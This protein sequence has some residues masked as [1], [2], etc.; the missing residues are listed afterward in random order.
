MFR[1]NERREGM[2]VAII[3]LWRNWCIA[4]GLLAVLCMLAT[5]V[6][7][8]W[9]VLINLSFYAVLQLVH[10]DQVVRKV[11][12]CYRLLKQVSAV[13]LVT[14]VCCFVLYIMGKTGHRIPR[15]VEP[16]AIH[17]P[18]MA[19]LIT[20]PV[21]A[22]VSLIYQRL[23]HEPMLCRHCN[24]RCLTTAELGSVDDLL[25]QEGRYQASLLFSLS[26]ILSVVDW[27]Y[28]LTLYVDGAMRTID[29]LFFIIFPF[30]IYSVTSL[31]LGWR[32][33]SLWLFYCQNDGLRINEPNTT[34]FRYLLI[35]DDKILLN[36][37][38]T[39]SQYRNGAM[40]KRFDTPAVIT[41]HYREREDLAEA[42]RLLCDEIGIKDV[43][44][45]YAYEGRDSIAKHTT[46]H[47]FVFL[48]NDEAVAQSKIEGEWMS[49]GQVAQLSEQNVLSRAISAELQRVYN[50]TMAWK[51]YDTRGRR[52][53]QIKNYKPTFRLRDIRNWDVDYN[54]HHWMTV[55][56]INEDKLLY[57][58]L[59]I[60][61]RNATPQSKSQV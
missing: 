45:R 41:T 33:Y 38:P 30:L 25:K 56:H 37:Y 5:V 61:M 1:A 47:Y 48:H 60:F 46:F 16:D 22:V 7:R 6:P 42:M 31:Y 32:Y 12:F 55:T 26:I 9:L 21:A 40:I 27:V 34:T 23:W 44:M 54:D 15:I 20:A 4:V 49:L 8:Q 10:R 3:G 53:Y 58:I 52:L 29:K 35:Y 28:Y 18:L 50:I 36:F 13:V 19:I 43:D 51:T 39:Q 57:P 24:R 2:T 14:A 11:P 17:S 59:K